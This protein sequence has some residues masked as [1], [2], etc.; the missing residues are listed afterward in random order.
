M[1]AVNQYFDGKVASLGLS[2]SFGKFTIGVMAAGEYEFNT[3]SVEIMTLVSGK[4][5]IQLPGSTDYMPYPEGS[6]FEVGANLTFKL[7]VLE[8]CG[9]LCQYK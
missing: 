4:W 7:K 8:D 3:S 9:Y 2:N 5:F 6:S 1:I